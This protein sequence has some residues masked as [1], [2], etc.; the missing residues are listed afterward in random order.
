MTSPS[1]KFFLDPALEASGIR[2]EPP[3]EG[4]AGFDLRASK[5]LL[6]PAGGQV[7]VPTGIKMAIPPGFVGLVRDRSSMALARVYTHAGVIDAGYRGEVK[8]V[9]SNGGTEPYHVQ[10]GDKIAQMVVVPCL[11]NC[12]VLRDEA[13]LGVTERGEGGFGSTGRR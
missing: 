5:E 10:A 3:R 7:L 4:D 13:D 8:V 1:V 11:T 2:F 12:Q 6:I 9:L